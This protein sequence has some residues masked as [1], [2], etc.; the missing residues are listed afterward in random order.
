MQTGTRTNA[1]CAV[2]GGCACFDGFGVTVGVRDDVFD[3]GGRDDLDAPEDLDD[4]DE[5][6]D[7]DDVGDAGNG[8]DEVEALVAECVPLA[9]WARVDVCVRR[10]GAAA[11]VVTVAT[12]VCA[13][14]TVVE[15]P[16]DAAFGRDEPHAASPNTSMSPTAIAKARIREL[17]RG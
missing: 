7:V 10:T 16:V 6:D 15:L 5:V 8:D 17:P 12:T 3:P 13:E 14:V 2:V 9:A 11:I 4:M 1:G